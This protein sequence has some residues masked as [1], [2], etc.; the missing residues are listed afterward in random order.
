QN[1]GTAKEDI[2]IG[3][4]N[5]EASLL[6]GDEGFLQVVRKPHSGLQTNDPRRSLDRVGGTHQRFDP[7]RVG[8]LALQPQQAIVQGRRVYPHP[9]AEQFPQRI[10]FGFSHHS[11]ARRASNS[12]V[13]SSNPTSRPSQENTPR[14]RWAAARPTVAGGGPIS[15]R[16]TRN[17]CPTASTGKT[18]RS[19]SR[20]TTNN[21]SVV[22][23]VAS[24]DVGRDREPRP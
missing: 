23:R 2:D 15:T 12:R 6:G 5:A 20:C 10:V 8:R 17:T 13:S 18:Q 21:R 16:G 4:G 1:V 22:A 7:L 19:A 3:R 14:D 9:L 24:S 11:L